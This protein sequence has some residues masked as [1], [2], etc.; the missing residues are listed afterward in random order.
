MEYAI[1]MG[2]RAEWIGNL[3][4]IHNYQSDSGQP[5]PRVKWSP[6]A[7]DGIS[8]LLNG[9][10]RYKLLQEQVAEQEGQLREVHG[11]MKKFKE[12][13]QASQ[14]RKQQ[15]E[16]DEELEKQLKAIIK[17]EGLF[18]VRLFDLGE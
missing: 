12:M 15:Q 2:I 9:N 16:T 7:K 1:Y 5:L 11:R 13:D 4:E 14:K 17:K 18:A 8:E 6:E 10:H 3:D